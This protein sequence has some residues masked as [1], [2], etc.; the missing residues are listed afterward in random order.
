MAAQS[1]YPGRSASHDDQ[2]ILR[3][4]PRRSCYYLMHASQNIVQGVLVNGSV[5]KV[6]E[7]I[8]Y[9][10]AVERYLPI[11]VPGDKEN[12]QDVPEYIRKS[13]F[14]WPLVKFTNGLLELCVPAEFTVE[15]A[16]GE[17]EATRMQVIDRLEQTRG[18]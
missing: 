4:V 17:I 7:L 3:D 6:V 16:L 8:T 15:D 2:G 14:P 11:A 12:G 10:E 9:K 18:T 1:M 5:G 13:T